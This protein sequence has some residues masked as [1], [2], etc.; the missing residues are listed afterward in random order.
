MCICGDYWCV[1]TLSDHLCMS[2]LKCSGGSALLQ[3]AAFLHQPAAASLG[4]DKGQIIVGACSYC[5]RSCQI[6]L[7]NWITTKIAKR[8]LWEKFPEIKKNV[9][10]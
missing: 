5:Q 8:I 4:R 9:S 2:R 1:I 7:F 10:T 6:L 3:P